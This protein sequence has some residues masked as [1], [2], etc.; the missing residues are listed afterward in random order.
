MI[1]SSGIPSVFI[2]TLSLQYPIPYIK[3]D[4]YK[5]AYAATTYLVEMGHQS[6]AMLAGN[7]GPVAGIPRLNGF[8][9]ALLDHGLQVNENLIKETNFR[10]DEGF[11]AMEKLLK[12]RDRFSAVF[13]CCDDVAVAA[14]SAVYKWG[15]EVPRDLSIIGYDNTR[16]AEMS[17]PPLTT[18]SQPL[19]LM[20]QE[21]VK[22]L[23]SHIKTG[24]QITNRI[25]PF[26][27]VERKSVRHI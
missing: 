15:L 2:S 13:A 6:I 9:Q 11:T 10:F 20:G 22:A 25:M 26:E 8:K 5:A 7:D 19:Y 23:I 1:V 18:V 16:V 12:E 14:I 17:N 4:D 24:S 21:A 3:V 27:I